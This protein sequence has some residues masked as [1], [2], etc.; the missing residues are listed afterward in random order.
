MNE[1][2]KEAIETLQ[3]I[4]EKKFYTHAF[5]NGT[6]VLDDDEIDLINAIRQS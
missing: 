3:D 5:D 6:L 4:K 1:K 2:E